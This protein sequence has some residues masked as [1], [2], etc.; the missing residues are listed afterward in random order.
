MIEPKE[1]DLAA[2]IWRKHYIDHKPPTEIDKELSLVE[3]E[4]KRAIKHSWHE[5][6]AF[7]QMTIGAWG[8]D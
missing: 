1:L 6:T 5:D 4:A 2:K 7:V 3:G 8:D